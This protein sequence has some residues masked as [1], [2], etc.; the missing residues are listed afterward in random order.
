M[1]KPHPST[2]GY[3]P[4]NA[5]NLAHHQELCDLTTSLGIKHATFKSIVS[6][7]AASPD[8]QVIFL[9]S[10]PNPVKAK[11]LAAARLVIYTP[12]NEHL[13]IVP[14]E[15]MLAG[16]PV[17]AANVG[18][19]TET[20]VEGRTGWLRDVDDVEQWVAVMGDILTG[21]VDRDALQ[22]M[23]Y[24]G[25]QRVRELFSKDTMASRLDEEVRKL[26]SA[27]RP[28]ILSPLAPVLLAALVVVLAVIFPIWY[29]RRG[30][31]V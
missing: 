14:L 17:L 24:Q 8:V 13:G 4:R 18:G 5:E 9:L 25:R 28:A 16:V 12:R 6:A 2:G 10:I 15:A 23:G 20:V 7:L 3:D 1:A 11:L 19:P 29:R 21:G 27:P 31:A 30:R 22:R 26:E